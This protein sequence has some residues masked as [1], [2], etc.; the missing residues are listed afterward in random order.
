MVAPLVAAMAVGAGAQ[1]ASGL[2]QYYNSEKA[3]GAAKERLDEIERMFDSIVP[4]ELDVKIYDDPEILARI[5]APMFRTD[6][7]TPE[8]YQ[9]VGQY[10]PQV[11]SFVAETNPKLVEATELAN[12]G[13]N[14]Q[15]EALQRFR[16]VAQG[17]QDPMFLQAMAEA[18]DRARGDAQSQRASLMQ[19]FARRGQLGS[20]AMLAT[21]L[22]ATGDNMRRAALES[23]RAAA[24]SYR[25]RMQAASQAAN[26]GG[27]IR[28]QEMNEAYRNADI[29]NDFNQRASQNYQNYA[30]YR[31]DLANQAQ[32]RNLSEA[33]RLSNANI[34]L[35]NE[36]A[37]R[38]R[39][40]Y[41]Q[42]AQLAYDVARQQRGDRLDIAQSKAN[43][44]NQMYQ[45]ELAKA[46][47]KAGISQSQVNNITQAAR[48]QNQV[49]Q[50]LGDAASAT[51]MMYGAYGSRTQPEPTTQQNQSPAFPGKTTAYA[52]STGYG[53]RG[54]PMT[55]AN[56]YERE[57]TIYD[58][59]F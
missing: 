3:R 17:E 21:Q 53:T 22:S 27:D 49:I 28:S 11:A 44:Q 51:A 45:N 39:A 6:A 1:V 14:A 59:R 47:G 19:D 13:R 24:E 7:I 46:Q 29:I 9:S 40:L 33:Q 26:L 56:P 4:P 20:G 58:V 35:R 55:V 8:M 32:L 37:I 41:N 23:Q 54:S 52:G 43:M 31:S 15:M 5:P 34:D 2:V 48:D 10:V 36:A 16:A 25:N 42:G 12:Q 30:K 18:S 50:G 38:N 57:E